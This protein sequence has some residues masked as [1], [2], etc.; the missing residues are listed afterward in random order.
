MSITTGVD[1]HCLLNKA[2]LAC[3]F[4]AIEQMNLFTE[5]NTHELRKGLATK[6][7]VGTGIDPYSGCRVWYKN[8]TP[9][10]DCD[11]YSPLSTK[12]YAQ[13]KAKKR[14]KKVKTNN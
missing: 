10:T 3:V 9:S 13:R 5:I 4:S 1:F 6:L 14:N 11:Q 2:I 8:Q 7:L 12:N